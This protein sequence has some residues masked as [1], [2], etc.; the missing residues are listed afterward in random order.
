MQEIRRKVPRSFTSPRRSV[1]ARDR[2]LVLESG[3]VTYD[4]KVVPVAASWRHP[5]QYDDAA[6]TR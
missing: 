4:S 2:V 5:L 3:R 6:R 1:G